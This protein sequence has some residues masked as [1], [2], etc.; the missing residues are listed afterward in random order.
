MADDKTKK[1]KID[2]KAR[3]GK[4]TLT[5][6][7]APPGA[8]PLPI[9]GSPGP[10]GSGLPPPD[11][12]PG[13]TPSSAPSAPGGSVPAPMPSVRPMGI[14]PPPGMSPGIP[15]PPFGQAPRQAPP[16]EAK[17]TAAQQTIKVEVGEGIHEERK[18]ATRNAAIAAVFGALVGL[19][20]GWVA[21]GSSERGG[22]IK[23]AA[24]GAGLLEKDVKVAGDKMKELD[25]K[26]AEATQ[27]ITAKEFPDG[28]VTALSA[29]NIPFDP[30]NLEGKNIGSLSSK[31]LRSLLSY[32]SAVQDLN[33]DK[34]SLKNILGAAQ[35]PMV[36]AWKEEKDPMANYAI[37][38]SGAGD[39]K[40]VGELVPIKEPFI[41]KGEFPA[42]ITV[43]KFENGKP[44]EKKATRWIKGE[45]TGGDP[46]VIPVDPK[47]MAGFTSEVLI[48]RLNKMIYDMRQSLVGNPE[49]PTNPK[50]GLLK[51]SEDIAA[52]LHKSSLNQ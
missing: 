16:K 19:G 36:K 7:A 17:P 42:N 4:A 40:T 45:L 14:A 1:T 44:A 34:D 9:P 22:R 15:L 30:T 8:L 39:K 21:G 35:A 25:D 12:G 43:T 13:A 18:R 11:S 47:S 49:D 28:L 3:L 37:L 29:L 26:L 6:I 51:Q 52:E 24:R 27:K 31:M 41:W 20:L 10:S 46:T 23:E 32:T 33:K 5:G 38:F 48:Q 50:P 2:L